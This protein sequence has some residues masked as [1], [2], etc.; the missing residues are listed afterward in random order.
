MKV[1][2]MNENLDR[3]I[4]AVGR[5]EPDNTT[6]QPGG[7]YQGRVTAQVGVRD[8]PGDSSRKNMPPS[9]AGRNFNIIMTSL[10]MALALVFQ[11][12]ISKH[13]DKLWI[14]T[15][16]CSTGN[17][18]YDEI[19]RGNAMVYRF[20][21]AL[22][23]Y[24][25][26][27]AIICKVDSTFM[28]AQMPTK[29]AILVGLIIACIFTPTYIHD[30]NGFA[31]LARI[32]AFL[33]V[34]IQ[35]LVLIEVAYE[36]NAR[37]RDGDPVCGIPGVV[38][39][40]LYSVLAF[41]ISIAAW[42]LMYIYFKGCP[43]NI[44]FIT[45]TIIITVICT[46]VQ[47]FASEQGSLFTS[48]TF[49]MYATY[50]CYSS[51]SIN[52][53]TECNPMAYTSRNTI[54]IIIG[55]VIV[56]SAV[57]WACHSASSDVMSLSSNKENREQP[58]ED[59]PDPSGTYWKSNLMLVLISMYFGMVLTGWAIIRTE[60][61]IVSQQQ[62]HVAM[63]LQICAQWIVMLLYLWTLIAPRLFPDRDFS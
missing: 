42:V 47:V 21:L 49:C 13:M 7:E 32:G 48:S 28:N 52:P 25:L 59:N 63:Y 16:D 26:S 41:C 17:S 51:V 62:G 61:T 43:S 60:G 50:I 18:D 40:L 36:W 22:S 38:I 27:M 2:S 33:Y 53:A 15:V 29:F 5:P 39:L 8:G 12:W 11:Y 19:C 44:A 58:T 54:Q 20:C 34:M 45:V 23:L 14:W 31:W 24:F 55:L 4:L 1:I 9:N 56:A 37:L 10:A 35:Q 6:H 3:P 46:L 30:L 57:A